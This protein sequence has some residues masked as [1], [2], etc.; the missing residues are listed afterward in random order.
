MSKLP[1]EWKELS[2][3]DICIPKGIRRGPFG[4]ALKKDIFVPNGYKVYEQK[5]AISKDLS[6]GQ[7][8]ITEEKYNEMEAFQ[9]KENDFLISCSGTIGKIVQIPNNYKQGIINQALLKLTLNNFVINDTFFK[10]QFESDK[11]QS[12]IVDNTQGGAMPNLV[13]MSI[14]KNTKF[15]IPP[16]QE[17]NKIAD[18]LSTVDKKIAFVEENINATEELKKGLMQKLLTEGI[19][20]TEFKNSE[21]GRI[22][23]SWEIKTIDSIAKISGRIGYRGYTVADIVKEGEG[24][25]TLSPSNII[26]N[27]INFKNCTFISF[28]KYEESPEIKIYNGDILLVK[29]G[30]TYGKTAIVMGLNEKATLNPQIVVLKNIKMNNLY[31]SYLMSSRIIQNQISQTIAGGAIPTL[32]QKNIEK[33]KFPLP[34][35]EEQ[36]QIAE[37]LLTVDNKLEN[38]KEKKQSFEELKKGLMQKLLTGEVRV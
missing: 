23:E 31:L 24:A 5:N 28:F 19:G 3:E 4:G 14:F 21:L 29:T 8:F 25:I 36:K 35:L 6:L 30:S 12:L 11:I 38:L 20:H 18:I 37:I 26:N 10:Y 15:I 2:L 32:S 22:P 34:L 27:K 13:G 1:R 9:V 17:Q 33:Y 16:L 7:Y